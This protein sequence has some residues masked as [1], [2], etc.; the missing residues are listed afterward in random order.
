MSLNAVATNRCFRGLT[1]PYTGKPITVRVVAHGKNPPMYFSP[2]AYDPSMPHQTVADLLQATGTRNGIIGAR[3]EGDE[4]VCAYTGAKLILRTVGDTFSFTG[5]FRPSQLHTDPL[6]FA[7][8]LWTRDGK[9]TGDAKLMEPAHFSASVVE[10][11]EKMAP[12]SEGP[13]DEARELVE[14]IIT[15][16]F[17]STAVSVPGNIPKRKGK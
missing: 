13:S 11:E 5:G 10:P 12:L 4:R 6:A 15:N 16:K 7:T 2:D 17:K 8:A 1:C 3:A 9:F 14:P